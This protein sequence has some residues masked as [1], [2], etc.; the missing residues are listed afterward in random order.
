MEI[1]LR[2][3]SS[4]D[5]FDGL[6]TDG[7]FCYRHISVNSEFCLDMRPAATAFCGEL[8]TWDDAV[9]ARVTGN[10]GQRMSSASLFSVQPKFMNV[11]LRIV[12]DVTVGHADVLISLDSQLLKIDGEGDLAVDED[13]EIGLDVD[14]QLLEGRQFGLLAGRDG[15]LWAGKL[16]RPLVK[17]NLK[18]AVG[19]RIEELPF[20]DHRQEYE[21]VYGNASGKDSHRKK[22]YFL[23]KVRADD[24]GGDQTTFASVPRKDSLLFVES[25][26]GRLGCDKIFP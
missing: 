14:P 17:P 4:Q 10:G 23:T 5:Y 9:D 21:R 3:L 26:R 20:D 12:L 6:P 13:V 1:I 15:R 25:L 16:M 11:D 19:D 7:H 2:R 24:D 18:S 22:K 8:S